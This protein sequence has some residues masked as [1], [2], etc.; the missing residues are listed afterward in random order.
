MV[1]EV[2]FLSQIVG[3]TSRALDPRKQM[4]WVWGGVQKNG[5]A[6]SHISGN[7]DVELKPPIID[8]VN[9]ARLLGSSDQNSKPGPNRS[10]RRLFN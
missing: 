7:G 9:R 6:G 5:M 10:V 1:T 8:T 2:S 3:Y 4:S